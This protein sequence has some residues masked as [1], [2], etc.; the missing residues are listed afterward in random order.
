METALTFLPVYTDEEIEQ[1]AALADIIWNECYGELLTE[2]QIRYMVDT[3]Q[4]A[5]PIRNQIQN[6]GYQYYIFNIGDEAAGYLSLQPR[7]GKLFLSKIY[8]KKEYRGKGYSQ[9]MFDFV[10]NAAAEK[11][12]SAVW[13]TV[14]RGNNRAIGA[15][16]KMGY[17]TIREQVADIGNGY[18]MDDYVMEKSMA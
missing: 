6:D 9:K 7:D 11:S 15:Y 10:H 12:C 2:G 16:R 13:L 17:A 14:N 8:L 5:T 3:I 4:S 1:V 18:V